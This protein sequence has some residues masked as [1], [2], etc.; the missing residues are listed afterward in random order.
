MRT[1]GFR[2]LLAGAATALLA[3][4]IA[5]GAAGEAR[6]EYPE[7]PV[8]LLVAWGAGG[9]TDIVAR[10]F[11]ALLE[12][13]LG[14]PVNV[15]NQTGG[16]GVVGHVAMAN[17]EP[18]GYTVGVATMEVTVYQSMGLADIGPDSYTP[19]IRLA[20]IPAGLT[21]KADS[22]YQSAEEL[23]AA[24]KEQPKGTFKSSGCGIGCAW[25]FAATGWMQKEGLPPDQILWIPSQGGA[26]ALQDLVA[27][28]LEMVTASVVESRSLL[29][30]GEIRALAV[31]ND[32]RQA[33]FPDVPTLEEATGADWS[34]STWFGLVGP[35]GMP[36][37]AVET[38]EAAAAKV[39]DSDAF[40]AFME[41]RGYVAV[42]ESP[43]EFQ[44][45]MAGQAEQ[46]SGLIEELGLAK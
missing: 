2:S 40:Q 17:A 8:T 18:D 23:L 44:A 11:A 27:G 14:Q 5:L 3:G 43:E 24:I 16:G 29:E 7:R 42:G 31:M 41:E 36:E 45:F 13:E 6:A 19:I 25:H 4:G 20:A 35:K 26:P 33:A 1:T 38:L 34:M 46:L 21:V 10:Q 30:A 9:G 12:Q 22:P 37:E 28:G 32:E 39:Y 15:V